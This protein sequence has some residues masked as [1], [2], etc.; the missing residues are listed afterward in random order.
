[1]LV[2]FGFKGLNNLE[3]PHYTPSSVRPRIKCSE[4]L[5]YSPSNE[6]C[7]FEGGIYM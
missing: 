6:G 2:S 4:D 7:C 5:L 3:P 1:M